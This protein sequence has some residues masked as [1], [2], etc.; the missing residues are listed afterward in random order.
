MNKLTIV[1]VPEGDWEGLYVNGKLYDEAHEIVL[2]EL[3]EYK[4]IFPIESIDVME[5][6]T[7]DVDEDCNLPQLLEDIL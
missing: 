4:D 7:F 5:Y 6:E 3:A 1:T 2:S